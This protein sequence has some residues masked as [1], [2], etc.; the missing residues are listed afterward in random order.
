MNRV[1]LLVDI[2]MVLQEVAWINSFV[3]NKTNDCNKAEAALIFGA[4]VYVIN[5]YLVNKV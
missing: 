3:A 5:L 4:A 2:K 1:R